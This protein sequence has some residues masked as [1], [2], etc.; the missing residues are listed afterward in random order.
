[1]DEQEV[2]LSISNQN[3]I[4]QCEAIGLTIEDIKISKTIQVLIKEHAES[5]ASDFYLAMCNIPEV[6]AIIQKYS[7]QERWIQKHAL[8]LVHAFD[9]HIDDSYVKR[10]HQLA[11]MHHGLGVLPQWYVASFHTLSHSIQT[12]LYQ[13]ISNQEEYIIISNSISKVLNFHQQ[14][15]LE[16]LEAVHMK[17]KQKEFQ[18]IKD[19]LKNKIFETSASLASLTE[20]TSASV[21]ELIQKSKMVSKE[22]KKGTT[23]SKDS[24]ILAKDG[25]Q[26]LKSLEERIQSIHQSTLSM[27]ETAE[28]LNQLSAQIRQVV[29]IVQDIARQTNLLSLNAA[30]EAAR[31]GEHGKG[32]AVVANE[33]RKLSEQTKES[34]EIIKTFTEQINEHKDEVVVS[35]QEVEQLVKDGYQ[36]SQ[37]TREAFDR[38]VGVANENLV[39]AQQAEL[40]IQNLVQI[41]IEIGTSTQK[42]VYSAEELNEA[43]NLA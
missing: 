34:V 12:N 35:I 41:I 25:Q 6:K 8:F 11:N 14:I 21:E 43:A 22:V 32:F 5:I 30:I 13:S 23:K 27:K 26:Q 42:I 20:E 17:T 19:E 33:V 9:G 4:N 40:D 3:I 31:A 7:N 37:V 1:M 24:Q 36:K 10:L 16:A 15:I 39:S 18:K 2:V 29:E 28:A 38:I